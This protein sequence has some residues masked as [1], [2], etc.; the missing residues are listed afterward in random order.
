[1]T[2]SPRA[3]QITNR[4]F[5]GQTSAIT[6]NSDACASLYVRKV[7]TVCTCPELILTYVSQDTSGF[8][9]QNQSQTE[10]PPLLKLYTNS[11]VPPDL[12][13][14][15]KWDFICSALPPFKNLEVAEKKTCTKDL[16]MYSFLVGHHS[17]TWNFRSNGQHCNFNSTIVSNNM[18]IGRISH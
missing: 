18:M 2:R 17:I 1:M 15:F 8:N 14:G 13:F 9:H 16:N 3:T 6:R 4:S 12:D 11:Y 10:H 5:E 7:P